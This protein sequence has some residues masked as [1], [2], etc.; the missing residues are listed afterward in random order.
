MNDN[1]HNH[2]LLKSKLKSREELIRELRAQM[3][4]DSRD[5]SDRIDELTRE[6]D[7]VQRERDALRRECDALRRKVRALELDIR[8]LKAECEESRQ[9]LLFVSE[10]PHSARLAAGGEDYEEEP[11]STA[12]LTKE[13]MEGLMARLSTFFTDEA[14]AKRY[15]NAVHGLRDTDV[16][17]VTNNY[18]EK[19]AFHKKARKTQLWRVLNEAKLYQ[20]RESNWNAMVNF[21]RKR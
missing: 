17:M 1:L 3:E 11:T 8:Q 14:T 20:A 4:A 10:T 18:W 12:Q 16:A 19:G 6:R 13:K 9:E 15:L 5:Y 7:T 2:T 21:S